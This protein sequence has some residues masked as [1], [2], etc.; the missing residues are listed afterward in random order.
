MVNARMTEGLYGQIELNPPHWVL[1]ERQLVN[2]GS[3]GGYHTF[4]PS[5]MFDG[6]VTLLTG[7]SESGKSTLVDAQVSLLYPTGAAFNKASNAGRSDRSDYSYLRGQRGIRN[8][9][10]HDEPVFLRGMTDDGEPYAVWGAIVDRYEDTTGG[11]TLSIAKFMTLPAGGR[12]EDVDKFFLVSR[13]PIDPRLMDDYRDDVF[14]VPLFKRVYRTATV[15]RQANLFHE[16]VWSRFG[17]TES[18]C[19]LLH[20]MQAS[21][22]PSQLDD[23]FRK[24]VLDEP[25]A[26]N[27]GRALIGDYTQFSENFTAIERNLH[28][29]DLLERMADKHIRYIDERKRMETLRAV[30]PGREGGAETRDAWLGARVH[31]CIAR[32]AP[33]YERG[34][35]ENQT[36]VASAQRDVDRL[37][38]ELETIRE[39]KNGHGGDRLQRLQ[40]QLRDAERERERMA[41]RIERLVPQFTKAGRTVP[42]TASAWQALAEEAVEVRDAYDERRKEIDALAYPLQ[43]RCSAMRRE[44]KDLQ[45]DIERNAGRA[46]ASPRRWRTRAR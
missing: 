9:N 37:D 22:A 28:R 7:Q 45:A 38:A 33:T 31:E 3:Y 23:I 44:A 4:D 16:D 27:R 36:K 26:L 25:S 2:W 5:T 17:L 11:G 46:H 14:S 8:D 30:D 34:I 19:R 13:D 21:D 35:A 42:G 32:V 20:R 6:T 43:E 12:S 15:Y 24:G 40:E 1:Q 18:A 41:A 29:V 39:Q 10:G